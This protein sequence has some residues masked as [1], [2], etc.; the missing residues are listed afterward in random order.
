MVEVMRDQV[1]KGS[2]CNLFV[3]NMVFTI[4]ADWLL[5]RFTRVRS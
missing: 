2:M 4:L 1:Y 5:H 3:L